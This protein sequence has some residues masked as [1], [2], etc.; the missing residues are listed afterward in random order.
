MKL[1]DFDDVWVRSAEAIDEG[2]DAT[3]ETSVNCV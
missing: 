2:S 1:I 3:C